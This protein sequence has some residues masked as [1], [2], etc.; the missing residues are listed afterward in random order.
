VNA[1][2][3]G[4][5]SSLA[6]FV[7][8]MPSSEVSDEVRRRVVDGFVDC[9]GVG[10]YGSRE[11]GARLLAEELTGARAGSAVVFG[12]GRGTPAEAALLNGFACHA[13]DYDDTLLAARSHL[14]A[15]V[16][17]A[18]AAA[19]AID[20][21]DG[22][23]A[24][25]AYVVAAEAEAAIGRLLQLRHRV[26]GWHP[27]GVIGA[28]GAAV[29][30]AR[31]FKLS[32]AQ[33]ETAL[34]IAASAACGVRANTGTMTKPLH[35]GL[36]ARA[37]VEA[38]L[39]A[40]R[41]FSAREG[42]LEVEAGFLDNLAPKGWER[43]ALPVF[44]AGGAIRADDGL[45]LKLYPS[46]S[47]THAAVD[48][49]LKLRSSV[50]DQPWSRVQV[51]TNA[52]ATRFLVYSEPGDPLQAKFSMQYCVAAAFVHGRLTNDQFTAQAIADRTVRDLMSG[53]AVRV[54]DDM[55]DDPRDPAVVEVETAGGPV[56]EAVWAAAGSPSN[57]VDAGKVDAKFIDC[58]GRVL[59]QADA[60]T[61][62]ARLR[63]L[64]LAPSFREVTE[65]LAF[66]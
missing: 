24:V 35:A 47:L 49:A 59:P 13:V 50:S 28:I 29:A 30:V 34:G 18:L 20:D 15:H 33:V 8:E 31:A 23:A 56:R 22:S 63:G 52:A 51:T 37:G 6:R 41:G 44:T 48:A 11:P 54:G 62:L 26:P 4:L 65:T 32:P 58:A 61:M 38:A 7:A 40:G 57:W 60:T 5:T 64:P 43:A 14:S 45:A 42:V 21:F 19:A 10:I 53:V 36:A 1:S 12:A 66:E 55:R 2:S 16:W 17:P 27:T 25:D 46:C 39:L 3:R 9:L